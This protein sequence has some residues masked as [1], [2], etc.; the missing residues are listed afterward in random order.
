MRRE[1]LVWLERHTF[2]GPV[3]AQPGAESLSVAPSETQ[4]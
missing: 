4:S 1:L 3:A 2:I